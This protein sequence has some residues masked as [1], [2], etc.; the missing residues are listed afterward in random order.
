LYDRRRL[1]VATIAVGLAVAATPPV[2]AGQPREG[3]EVPTSA[4]EQRARELYAEGSRLYDR[5]RYDGA[6]ARFEEA[7]A[8]FP[9]PELLF[10][11]AQ[12]YRLRGPAFCAAALRY[13]EWYLRDD[14]NAG[15]R[16]E[17]EEIVRD[18]RG[19]SAG[20]REPATSLRGGT[21]ER[22]LPFTSARLVDPS[23][24][25]PSRR[26]PVWGGWAIC[27]LILVGVA[28]CGVARAKRLFDSFPGGRSH[29]PADK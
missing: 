9:R 24:K 12:A 29:W 11:I 1:V 22:R 7:Y 26:W 14:P 2:E 8:L 6:L 21:S 23:Q 16:S 20:P 19:C 18:M 25:T 28:G 27:A 5:A 15:N 10:N 17:I 3:R 4:A 13:Y